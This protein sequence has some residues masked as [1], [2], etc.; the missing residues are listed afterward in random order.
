[1]NKP[2]SMQRQKLTDVIRGAEPRGQ[3][4]KVDPETG[5]VREPRA[6][7]R[8]RELTPDELRV[9]DAKIAHNRAVRASLEALSPALVVDG[10]PSLR[11]PNELIDVSK[12]RELAK[13][14]E[15]PR[16]SGRGLEGSAL[17]VALR[18]YDGANGGEDHG[19]YVLVCAT[20]HDGPGYKCRTRGAVIRRPELRA[21]A[22]VLVAEA[23]RRDALDARSDGAAQ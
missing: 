20:F 7:R 18:D 4:V 22:A 17:V 14:L 23:D 5:E 11:E 12:A 1:M 13:L 2:H 8:K 6:T 10:D 3:S 9:R 15:V 21:V 16:L 19:P